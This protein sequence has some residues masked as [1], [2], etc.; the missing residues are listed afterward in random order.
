M[1]FTDSDEI[2]SVIGSGTGASA[3]EVSVTGSDSTTGDIS[4]AVSSSA[5]GWTV[6]GSD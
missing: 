6:V 3:A 4:V 5:D 1:L 2:F